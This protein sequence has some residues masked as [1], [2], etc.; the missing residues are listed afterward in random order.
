MKNPDWGK[1]GR[2]R[3]IGSIARISFMAGRALS[4]QPASG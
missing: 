1:S 2:R 4:D 3:A